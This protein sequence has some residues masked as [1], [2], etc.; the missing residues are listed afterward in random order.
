MRGGFGWN[1][2]DIYGELSECGESESYRKEEITEY[3]GGEDIMMLLG[4]ASGTAATLEPPHQVIRTA[5][6]LP[7]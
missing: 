1:G 5:D 2:P 7:I 4:G 3:R 6:P